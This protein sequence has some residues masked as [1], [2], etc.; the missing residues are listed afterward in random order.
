MAELRLRQPLT[1]THKVHSL[2]KSTIRFL[3]ESHLLDIYKIEW[4]TYTVARLA[5]MAENI[6]K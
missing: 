5:F 6:R 1:R 3:V 2:A 4:E